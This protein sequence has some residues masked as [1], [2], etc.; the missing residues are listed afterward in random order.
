MDVEATDRSALAALIHYRHSVEATQTVEEVEQFFHTHTDEYA[1][2]VSQGAVVDMCG[3]N[4]HLAASL[5]QQRELVT[6]LHPSQS[7]RRRRL[8]PKAPATAGSRP[9][10]CRPSPR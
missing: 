2:V 3:R 7:V 1:A 9:K 6:K 10:D 8:H 4:E 5:V